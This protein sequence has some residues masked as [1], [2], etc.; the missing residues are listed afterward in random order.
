MFFT[1]YYY[2]IKLEQSYS[3]YYLLFFLIIFIYLLF[4]NKKN[5]L[6]KID[7]KK[8]KY[9]LIAIIILSFLILLFFS[10]K[11]DYINSRA[12]DYKAA[13]YFLATEQKYQ[14]CEFFDGDDCILP[15]RMEKSPGYPF[16]LSLLFIL[17]G[18][19]SIS[20]IIF[21]FVLAIFIP[22][23]LYLLLY[24]LISKKWLSF[25]ISCLFLVNSFYLKSSTESEVFNISTFFLLFSFFLV[26][27][28]YFRPEPKTFYLAIFSLLFLGF[29]RGEYIIFSLLFIV[30]NYKMFISCFK[31]KQKFFNYI[32]VLFFAILLIHNITEIKIQ[33]DS[34]GTFVSIENLKP[35]ENHYSFL[36]DFFFLNNFIF[37]LPIFLFSLFYLK[38]LNNPRFYILFSFLA[39][40]LII[41]SYHSND[42][43]RYFIPHTSTFFLCLGLGAYNIFSLFEYKSV[44]VFVYFLFFI[45]F[46]LNI[47]FFL[48]HGGID[49][50][51]ENFRKI[52][53]KIPNENSFVIFSTQTTLSFN[54]IDY[55]FAGTTPFY[56]NKRVMVSI[57][58]ELNE[59]VPK[60]FV[61][62]PR[63]NMDDIVFEYYDTKLISMESMSEGKIKLFRLI[64]KNTTANL[65]II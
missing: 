25:F 27:K 21:N 10:P 61:Q 55:S 44:K 14:I 53:E 13:G 7:L 8:N 62:I 43:A 56:E 40:T 38:N 35:D 63:G 64:E 49:Y 48:K 46:L 32:F 24:L 3:F 18:A 51:G 42:G 29:L 20:T 17:F 19:S 39:F 54:I 65:S 59:S 6:R 26:I 28:Y 50:D 1:F 57:F 36:K 12:H 34:D 11:N 16:I 45:V 15:Y 22:V 33:S 52:M 60:Y 23:L 2:F 31:S 37:V 58:R 47:L 9:F 30:L 4:I 41:L 5:I